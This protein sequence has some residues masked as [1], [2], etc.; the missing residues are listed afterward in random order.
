[1]IWKYKKT[2]NLKLKNTKFLNI[3]KNIFDIKK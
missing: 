1:M 3:F 2:I